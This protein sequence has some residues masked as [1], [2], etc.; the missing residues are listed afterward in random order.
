MGEVAEG[1]VCVCTGIGTAASLSETRKIIVGI[2]CGVDWISDAGDITS[3][4]VCVASA[5]RDQW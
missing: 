5:V 1:V 2:G 3:W 4:S